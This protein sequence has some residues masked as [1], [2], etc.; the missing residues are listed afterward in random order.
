[1]FH[2]EG[3]FFRNIQRSEL[4]SNIKII[5][6]LYFAFYSG[7]DTDFSIDFCSVFHKLMISWPYGFKV[8]RLA[9][10]S[11]LPCNQADWLIHWLVDFKGM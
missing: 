3:I 9:Y 1:M 5:R 6:V 2:Y 10:C 4:H 7:K 11:M 8:P